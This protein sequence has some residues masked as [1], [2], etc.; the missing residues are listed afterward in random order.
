MRLFIRA[1]ILQFIQC[2][3]NITHKQKYSSVNQLF[4]SLII[5]TFYCVSTE[6]NVIKCTLGPSQSS[7]VQHSLS[8]AEISV[9]PPGNHMPMQPRFLLGLFLSLK[10]SLVSM[11]HRSTS[12][13]Y[14]PDNLT[15]SIPPPLWLLCYDIINK[16]R[17][18]FY[19]MLCLYNSSLLHLMLHLISISKHF[20]CSPFIVPLAAFLSNISKQM[21]LAR[22]L[23]C[24][25]RYITFQKISVHIQNFISSEIPNTSWE[26]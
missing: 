15:F 16:Y 26:T 18:S 17:C 12:I 13:L 3:A 21:S 6:Y 4:K 24:P 11:S 23:K 10:L 9:C 19:V 22:I 1:V 14:S 25:L 2:F 7:L 20:A 5:E 8:S